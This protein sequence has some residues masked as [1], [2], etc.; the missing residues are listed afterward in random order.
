[1]YCVLCANY[2]H[3]VLAI[4]VQQVLA[5]ENDSRTLLRRAQYGLEAKNKL[6]GRLREEVDMFMMTP[7]CTPALCHLD[8][9]KEQLAF[10]YHRISQHVISF[11]DSRLRILPVGSTPMQALCISTWAQCVGYELICE[12]LDSLVKEIETLRQT[13]IQAASRSSM[14][15]SVPSQP[16]PPSPFPLPPAAAQAFRDQCA[17]DHNFELS[18]FDD[19]ESPRRQNHRT[20]SEDM[21][22]PTRDDG[23]G[24]GPFFSHAAAGGPRLGSGDAFDNEYVS[25]SSC[26]EL[27]FLSP[28][29]ASLLFMF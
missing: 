17:E 20:R 8:S 2:S 21:M 23:G 1:L 3:R 5:Q 28:P 25:T 19:T 14:A 29:P 7:E 26:F 13:F 24:G 4:V 22:H 16:E 15:G 12:L 9:L 18:V 11:S 27:I 10:H 6:V